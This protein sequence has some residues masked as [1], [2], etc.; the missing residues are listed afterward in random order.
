MKIDVLSFLATAAG[1]AMVVSG[2]DGGDLEQAAKNFKTIL[3]NIK[4]TAKGSDVILTK[5]AQ[6]K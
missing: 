3:R 4:G 5:K 1:L 2:S 6:G